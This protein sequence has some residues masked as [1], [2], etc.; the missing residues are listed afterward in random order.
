MLVVRNFKDA[1]DYFELIE[2]DDGSLICDAYDDYNE[3][4]AINR[5]KEI[6]GICVRVNDTVACPSK[7]NGP[8]VVNYLS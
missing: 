5:A 6:N 3:L 4:L 2:N 1:S 7:W 8:V